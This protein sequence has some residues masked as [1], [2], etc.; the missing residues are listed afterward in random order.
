MMDSPKAASK[1]CC[2]GLLVFFP[3][4]MVEVLVFT[5]G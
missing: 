2:F 1:V 5:V 4:G 3:G